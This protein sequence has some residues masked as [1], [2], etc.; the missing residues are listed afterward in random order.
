M[1]PSL[2]QFLRPTEASQAANSQNHPAAPGSA[3][4][5]SP[6]GT[7]PKSKHQR[8]TQS[9]CPNQLLLKLQEDGP[10]CPDR[11]TCSSTSLCKISFNLD[12]FGPEQKYN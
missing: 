6:G 9:T 3:T 12:T 7:G 4:R 8:R 1:H 10:S 11:S 5:L 2:H